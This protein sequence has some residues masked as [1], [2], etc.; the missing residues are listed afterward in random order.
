MRC[1]DVRALLPEMRDEG[2]VDLRVQRHLEVCGACREEADRYHELLGALRDLRTVRL[3]PPDDLLAETLEVVGGPS[4]V[5]VMTSRQKA[6]VAGAVGAVAAGAAAT[7]VVVAKRRGLRLA[8][9][10]AR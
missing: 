1:D 2:P 10:L 7:A 3:V 5:K 8:A 9:V 6:A 4:I